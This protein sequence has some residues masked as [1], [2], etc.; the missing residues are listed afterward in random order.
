MKTKLLIENLGSSVRVS[1]KRG[2]NEI[3]QTMF[4][5]LAWT[6]KERHLLEERGNFFMFMTEPKKL[7]RIIKSFELVNGEM[8]FEIEYIP[9]NTIPP[10][11][12][13]PNIYRVRGINFQRLQF[14][15]G[16][17]HDNL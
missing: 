16:E 2:Q 1:L 4:A 5:N 13:S 8:G 3:A 11:E 12:Y 15:I 17:A 9:Q 14:Q 10:P 6:C 7:K